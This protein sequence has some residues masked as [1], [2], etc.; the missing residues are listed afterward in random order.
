[1]SEL[2]PLHRPEIWTDAVANYEALRNRTRANLPGSRSTS[3]AEWRPV[4]SFWT[5]PRA[6]AR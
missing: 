6:R 3:R 4:N 5:W 2:N 1:M